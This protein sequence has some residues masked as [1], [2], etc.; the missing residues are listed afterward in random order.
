[1]GMDVHGEITDQSEQSIDR[2]DQSKQSADHIRQSEQ[3][4]K[5]SKLGIVDRG[6][7]AS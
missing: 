2:I 7:R 4:K 1:M 5:Q 6:E 3:S